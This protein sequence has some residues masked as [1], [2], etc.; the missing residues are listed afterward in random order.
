MRKTIF[1]IC[2]LA[3]YSATPAFAAQTAN[4]GCQ[5]NPDTGA[6][7]AT[8]P[9]KNTLGSMADDACLKADVKRSVAIRESRSSESHG[10]ASQF[11]PPKQTSVQ[12]QVAIT[13]GN[14]TKE[15]ATVSAIFYDGPAVFQVEGVDRT[16]VQMIVRWASSAGYQSRVN[17]VVTTGFF[18]KHAIAYADIPIHLAGVLKPKISLDKAVQDVK[19]KFSGGNFSELAFDASVDPQSQTVS[20]N[21]KGK[22]GAATHK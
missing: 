12:K 13:S 8:I 9:W 3:A 22:G 2:I 7:E 5:F 17:G 10:G 4:I 6:L 15:V 1:T 14:Q 18:P 16:V 11:I 21:I 20:I 19:A